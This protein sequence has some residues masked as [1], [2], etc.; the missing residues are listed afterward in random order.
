MG[1]G[2]GL[3]LRLLLRPDR[4]HGAV[5]VVQAV[6]ADGDADGH[7]VP[8]ALVADLEL[9]GAALDGLPVL[10]GGVGVVSSESPRPGRVSSSAIRSVCAVRRR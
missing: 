1:T 2:F 9:K 3:L 10:A 4:V 5:D 8:G 7:L 6:G